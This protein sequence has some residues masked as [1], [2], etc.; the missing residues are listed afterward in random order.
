MRCFRPAKIEQLG[1]NRI[2]FPRR[3]DAAFPFVVRS[4]LGC[5]KEA[6]ANPCA[7]PTQCQNRRQPTPIGDTASCDH[8]KRRYGVH[9]SGQQH[10]RADLAPDMTASLIALCA[11]GVCTQIGSAPGLVG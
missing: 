5:R 10:H 2:R 1:I 7:R 3:K 6:R 4:G 9:H 8:R 11:D